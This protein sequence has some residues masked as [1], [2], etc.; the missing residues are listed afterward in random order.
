MEAW[1]DMDTPAW[2]GRDLK[3]FPIILGTLC[4]TEPSLRTLTSS[5][6]EILFLTDFAAGNA[7]QTKEVEEFLADIARATGHPY[8]AVSIEDDWLRTD[9]VPNTDLHTYLQNVGFSA[10]VDVL[11][12]IS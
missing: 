1:P 12:L 9:L 8:R 6:T 4:D 3:L 7:D 11:M 5:H 10:Y 2:F